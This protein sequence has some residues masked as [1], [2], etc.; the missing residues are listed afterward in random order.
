M[1]SCSECER[2]GV[3]T[4]YAKLRKGLCEKHYRRQYRKT[5]TGKISVKKAND[6]SNQKR[7]SRSVFAQ[8]IV[9]KEK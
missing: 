6:K 1:G 5:E 9:K 8:A 7:K 2:E 4:N 3:D